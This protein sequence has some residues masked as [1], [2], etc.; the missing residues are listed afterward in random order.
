MFRL[1]YIGWPIYIGSWFV[2]VSSGIPDAQT[3]LTKLFTKSPVIVDLGSHLYPVVL[4]G[5][6][7]VVDRSHFPELPRRLPPLPPQPALSFSFS[8]RTTLQCNSPSRAPHSPWDWP[9]ARFP[10]KSHLCPA[11]SSGS[12]PTSPHL[13][14]VKSV[15]NLEYLYLNPKYF[16]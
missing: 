16:I 3:L 10:L 2:S 15:T 1:T 13:A 7:S 5:E 8:D 12:P 11:F 9:E 4:F 6:L 14:A